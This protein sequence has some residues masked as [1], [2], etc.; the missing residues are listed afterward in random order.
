MTLLSEDIKKQVS[1]FFFK[2]ESPVQVLFFGRSSNCDYCEDTLQLTKEVVEL[3][4]K[5]DLQVYDLD[6]DTE[7]AQKYHVDKAPSIVLL[8]SNG[9]D[10]M[11]HGVRFLGIPAGHEFSS[12]IQGLVLVSGGDSQLNQTTRDAL[13]KISSPV[14]LQVYVTPTCPYC[15]QAVVLA[16]QMALESPYVQ[17]EMIEATEFPELAERHNVNGVPQITIN[18]GAGVVVGAVPEEYLLAEILRTASVN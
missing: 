1:E 15:P 16:H 9:A 10:F 8:G 5:L 4:D 11:D 17:A 6:V 14:L 18:D 12:L 7:I 13:R 2:L 3:S